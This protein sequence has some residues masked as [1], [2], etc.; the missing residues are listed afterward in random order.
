MVSA[1]G[2]GP[3]ER[4]AIAREIRRRQQ[5]PLSTGFRYDDAHSV[6]TGASRSPDEQSRFLAANTQ[7]T[8]QFLHHDEP[9]E[10]L[11]GGGRNWNPEWTRPVSVVA[12]VLAIASF[13]IIANVT[14]DNGKS[15][16]FGNSG[17]YFDN[18]GVKH[19]PTSAP[20]SSGFDPGT[21]NP[22]THVAA[23]LAASPTYSR[24]GP[25]ETSDGD[26]TPTDTSG[27]YGWVCQ[28]SSPSGTAAFGV[29][30]ADDGS[31]GSCWDH[32]ESVEGDVTDC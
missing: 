23:W 11:D 19:C 30:V 4:D 22:A 32:P 27:G 12:L 3:E 29:S 26:C 14:D 25:W 2:A 21:F 24:Q 13:V 7:V 6:Q 17:C 28:A 8:D 15:N 1:E 18:V 9:E 31:A 10:P 5:P 20:A 16:T